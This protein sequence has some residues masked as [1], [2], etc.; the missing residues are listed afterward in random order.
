MGSAL[1]PV[2]SELRSL[3]EAPQSVE[4]RPAPC[5]PV[6][7]PSTPRLSNFSPVPFSLQSP[8]QGT[9][10]P[11][12]SPS[13]P[14]PHTS[15][16]EAKGEQGQEGQHDQGLHGAFLCWAECS[17]G[18]LGVF[19]GSCVPGKG[20][21]MAS[22][23]IY[24][25]STVAGA[26]SRGSNCGLGRTWSPLCPARAHKGREKW[27]QARGGLG[28]GPSPASL[29]V[30]TGMGDGALGAPCC[31]PQSLIALSQFPL[32]DPRIIFSDTGKTFLPKLWGVNPC[33]GGI[34]GETSTCF[35]CGT[36]SLEEGEQVPVPL[37]STQLL[38]PHARGRCCV[39]RA[40]RAP[41]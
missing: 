23:V 17:P 30:P 9:E 35:C 3:T 28:D 32:L 38:L 4:G 2:L 7:V 40:V 36:V 12:L 21:G 39:A 18:S 19:I 33:T 1:T 37:L 10:S 16:A 6:V 26:A 29:A 14:D 41:D 24:S 5:L 20:G 8:S 11:P 13:A 22:W 25:T 27:P 34:F 15:A 31:T